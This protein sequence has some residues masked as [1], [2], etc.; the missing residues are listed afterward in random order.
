MNLAEVAGF[1]PAVRFRTATFEVAGISR[2]PIPPV[3]GLPGGTR[4]R[5]PLHPMQVR[6]QLRYRKI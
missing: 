1:E 4:T 6:Y 2:S 3:S 5:G